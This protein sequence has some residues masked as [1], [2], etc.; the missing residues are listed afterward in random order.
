MTE[1]EIE[2]Q[3]RLRAMM[4]LRD[5][6]DE[7]YISAR[8]A[9]NHKLLRVAVWQSLHCLEK[10]FKTLLVLRSVNVLQIGHSLEKALQLVINNDLKLELT[11]GAQSYIYSLNGHTANVR[12]GGEY[13]QVSGTDLPYL[14][15][16]VFELRNYC[17]VNVLGD[18]QHPGSA[19]EDSY[20]GFLEKVMEEKEYRAR[21]ALVYENPHFNDPRPTKVSAPGYWNFTNAA[22]HVWPEEVLNRVKRL[23]KLDS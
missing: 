3:V 19:S 5:T 15:M 16:A 18:I 11:P 4:A 9:Y 17:A 7:D 23:V 2:R 12:Y 22:Q 1:S 14:D 6:A 8:L 13:T 10:Y 20:K 21:A